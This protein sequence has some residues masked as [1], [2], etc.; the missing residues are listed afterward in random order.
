MAT[1]LHLLD[2]SENGAKLEVDGSTG[3][4]KTE[5]FSWFYPPPVCHLAG[6][7]HFNQ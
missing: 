5:E 2:D 6:A 7:S 1:N 3:A 4:L